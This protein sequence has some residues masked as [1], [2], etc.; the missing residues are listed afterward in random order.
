MTTEERLTL[1]AQ[2]ASVFE[3]WTGAFKAEDLLSWYERELSTTGLLLPRII[4][5]I[6]SGN[7]PHA[8]WQTLLNGLMLGA[9]NFLKLPSQ[10]LEGFEKE[11][12]SSLRPFIETAR[13]LPKDWIPQADAMVV[14]GSDATIRHFRDLA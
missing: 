8:A 14:Y 11:I 7:T 4:V 2:E 1:I 6:I 9:K 10:G 13:V 5:H 3:P 12:P